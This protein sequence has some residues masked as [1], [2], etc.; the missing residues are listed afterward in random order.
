MKIV[1]IALAAAAGM[2]AA[3]VRSG[4]A[5]WIAHPG[6]YALW[7]GNELMP[8]RIERGHGYPPSW[9]SYMHHPG[10]HFARRVDLDRPV[11]IRVT[12]K[13]T[14]M[15]D[16]SR[17][18]LSM[19]GDGGECTLPKGSYYVKVLV[20]NQKQPPALKIEGD[21]LVTDGE[22]KACWHLTD[23]RLHG[24]PVDVFDE[25]PAKSP[26][27]TEPAA[28]A[29]VEK[30]VNGV[31]GDLGR[32]DFGF[33]TLTGVSGEGRACVVYGESEGEA[34]EKN[35]A[36][37]ET[38]E[39]VPL[40]AGDNRLPVSRGFRFVR[41]EPDGD[42]KIGG[43][44]FEREF[45][46]LAENGSFRSSDERLNEIWRVSRRTLG[47]TFRE[48]P[49][50]GAK[51]DRWT[52]SGDAIQSHLMNYYVFGE[53]KPVRDAVWYLRGRDPVVSHIN[54]I[55]DY[56]FYWFISISDYYLY[57]GDERFL[58]QV[59]PQMVTL[60]DFVISRL[61]RDGRPHDMPGDWMFIDWAPKP[62][63]NNGGVTSFETILLSRA[64]E[65]IAEVGAVV[66]APAEAVTGY[67]ARAAALRGWVKPTF[68]NDAKGGLMH[69]RK[70]D[71]TFDPQFT[72]YPNIFGLLY[73][74]FT[75]EETKRVVDE[76][77]LNDG[78]MKL[79]TPYMRFYE[80]AALAETGLRRKVLDEIRGYWGAMLDAGATAFWELY[81]PDEKGE[82]RYA[83]YGRPYGKSLCHAWG[84]S[85]AYLLGRYFLGVQPVK[86]GFAEYT[87]A[88]DAAG[89]AEMEG[90]VPTPS[91]PVKVS[92][93]G[94]AVT[95]TGNGGRGVLKW[96][97]G[98]YPIAPRSTVSAGE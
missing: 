22:W 49:V 50:E 23:W 76:V 97:G 37:L 84:A 87:V 68:W 55:M 15:V 18:T 53:P 10:V 92:V 8:R 62:L 61:D 85:P 31:F 66:G 81:N 7:T 51:R 78:V 70:D 20:F 41:V 56:S 64:M 80:L 12:A 77:L 91:G 89:L 5:K 35:P 42:L 72:R 39:S 93:R 47:L 67:R 98:E 19:T 65:A 17:G 94:G 45:Y 32:E 21:G 59:Y 30:D 48:I 40:K 95:V 4:E 60:M 33:L 54:F 58:R 75:P 86:P 44:E 9:P 34:R 79:Q 6:D 63:V 13:G 52:W 11:K 71:G 27:R 73:G 38:W 83:M 25:D 1:K 46:P 26:L 82:A 69:I 57:T 24:E 29:K 43:L 96:N 2:V 90:A 28:F 16:G 74:Y 88:P 36:R 14:F 3:S